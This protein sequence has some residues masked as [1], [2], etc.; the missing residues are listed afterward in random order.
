ME[1]ENKKYR[2]FSFRLSEETKE[3]L[4]R[5]REVKGKSWNRFIY[6]MAQSHVNENK[7]TYRPAFYEDYRKL[8]GSTCENCGA[9]E[10]WKR[11]GHHNRTNM[12]AH[13]IDDDITNNKPENIQTLCASCHAKE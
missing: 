5:M 3:L 13:H 11:A 6:E 8:R 9:E 4:N 1:T 2:T 7:N 12:A 10:E